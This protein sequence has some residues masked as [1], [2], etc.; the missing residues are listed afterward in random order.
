MKTGMAAN[1]LP[2]YGWRAE[3]LSKMLTTGTIAGHEAVTLE[4]DVLRVTVLPR[5]GADIYS[6]VHKPSGVD[7]LMKT[8]WGLKPPGDKPPAD[9]LQ[10]YE[11]AWQEIFPSG[12]DACEY[13]GATIPFHGEAALLPWD[14]RP[15]QAHGE[16]AAIFSMRSPATGLV[17][18]RTMRLPPGTARLV[19]EETVTNPGSRPAD[20]VWGHHIV[21]GAPFLED[22]CRVD[23]PAAT[24]VTPDELYEPASA[25]LAPGQRQPWPM[26]LGRRPGERVDL[27]HVPGPQVHGHDDAYLVG[28]REGRLAVTSPRQRLRFALAWDAAVF[29]C[30]VFW[31]PFGGVEQPPLTGIY[32]LGVE[33][34]VSRFNLA[35]A[36]AQGEALRL[37]P[38]GV[39]RTDLTAMVETVK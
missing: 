20:F 34:W 11:G 39:L 7:V 33:P 12:N 21:L 19:L 14:W 18:E 30:I 6:L 22:G 4:N 32:G 15:V 29:R 25:R 13:R 2:M 28:L 24:V 37:E 9:F 27:R 1:I 16:N 26:A 3:S 5:K 35:Q 31:Q 10:N 8:P 36:V 23:I 17:L 38:Q